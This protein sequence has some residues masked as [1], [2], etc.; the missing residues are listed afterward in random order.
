ML[1]YLVNNYGYYELLEHN[2]GWVDKIEKWV[3]WDIVVMVT[4]V[5]M[6]G[7][8]QSLQQ[9]LNDKQDEAT[10]LKNQLVTNAQQCDKDKQFAITEATKQE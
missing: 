3:V 2:G 10:S 6:L 4:M 8:V 7:E 5:T 9:K 1:L